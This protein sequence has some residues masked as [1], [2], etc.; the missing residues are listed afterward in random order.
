MNN[1]LVRS[2]EI[3]DFLVVLFAPN[4]L[5]SLSVEVNKCPKSN[6]SIKK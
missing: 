2:A 4:K 1:N 5:E 6:R 3:F